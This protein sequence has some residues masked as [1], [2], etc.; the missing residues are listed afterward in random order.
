MKKRMNPNTIDEMVGKIRE[1]LETG[2][3]GDFIDLFDEN[4]VMEFPFAIEGQREKIEGK[5]K[6]REVYNSP[7]PMR[8][9]IEIRKIHSTIHQAGDPDS[10]IVEFS[11]EGKIIATGKD[12]HISSSVAI[13]K[14]R[15]GKILSYKDYPNTIGFAKITGMGP[16]LLASLSK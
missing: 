1:A 6:I 10:I 7:S 4:G 9:L 8:K 3:N 15:N 12:F 2:R 16:Q 14:G 11:A 5:E 13:I